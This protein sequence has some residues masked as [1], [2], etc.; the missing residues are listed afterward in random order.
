M[1]Y[2]VRD[3]SQSSG[4]I[5]ASNSSQIS[6]ILP[7]LYPNLTLPYPIL[8]YSPRCSPSIPLLF[9]TG[10][11]N[12]VKAL[13]RAY[14]VQSLPSKSKSSPGLGLCAEDAG[15]LH[16]G[17]DVDVNEGEEGGELG[18]G[19]EVEDADVDE[20]VD[21]CELVVD[22]EADDVEAD[23]DV[24]EVEVRRAIFILSMCFAGSLRIVLKFGVW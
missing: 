20:V 6:A 10:G 18:D 4:S 8:L 24:D 16:L 3:I 15:V 2:L 22:D 11:A 9:E 12:L 23:V 14:V 1:F 17:D 19:D 13:D 7:L 5:N 21:W